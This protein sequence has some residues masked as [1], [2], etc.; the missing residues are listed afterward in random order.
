MW[1]QLRTATSWTSEVFAC[2]PAEFVSTKKP[3]RR[4]QIASQAQDVF[5][6][7]PG[8]ENYSRVG[9]YDFVGVSR[10]QH[11]ALLDWAERRSAVAKVA[12]WAL[13]WGFAQAGKDGLATVE[14]LMT[15]TN[16]A[17]RAHPD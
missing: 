16:E 13:R 14:R 17:A 1:E 10:A 4:E 5:L 15:G 2:I 12:D 6:S 7:V 9:M 3:E 11:R 8:L